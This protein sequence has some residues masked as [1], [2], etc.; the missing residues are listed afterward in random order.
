[1]ASLWTNQSLKNTQKCQQCEHLIKNKIF[2][3]PSDT[4]D[5]HI[6]RIKHVFLFLWD[7]LFISISSIENAQLASTIGRFNLSPPIF[8]RKIDAV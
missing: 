6:I 8:N 3:F 1:M 4:G 2:F 7:F 5:E